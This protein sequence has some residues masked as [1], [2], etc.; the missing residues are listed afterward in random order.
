LAE[1]SPTK[2]VLL[3]PLALQA[4]TVAL[5]ELLH[6]TLEQQPLAAVAVERR[7]QLQLLLAA[8]LE[9]EPHL[10]AALVVEASLA[11]LHLQATVVAVAA[12]LAGLMVLAVLEVLVL[13]PLHQQILLAV[14][15]G[16]MAAVLM[17]E[18]LHLVLAALAVTTHLVLAVVLAI[19]AGRS[20]VAV[21]G[22]F[23]QLLWVVT[24]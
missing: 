13:A 10:T 18:M 1:V 9:L 2:L 11:M 15:V 21:A 8:L 17:V 12:G 6:G 24:V 3:A 22:L 5:V 7:R 23:L 14:V 19:P 4:E 16:A 20:V